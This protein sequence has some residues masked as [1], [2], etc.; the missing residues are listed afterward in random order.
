MLEKFV[1]YGTANHYRPIGYVRDFFVQMAKGIAVGLILFV[2][3]L[4]FIPP[5][6]ALIPGSILAIACGIGFFAAIHD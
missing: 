3:F 5:A 1:E 6:E 2:L 4:L